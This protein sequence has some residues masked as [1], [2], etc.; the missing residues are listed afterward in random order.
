MH[1]LLL[2][3]TS[4]TS[5]FII[6]YSYVEVLMKLFI[7]VK[8]KSLNGEIVL[9]TGAAHGL[10]RGTAYAFAKHGCKLVLWDINKVHTE[11]SSL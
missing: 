9:I 4:V 5:L 8:K 7:P 3:V 6:L 11:C 10:G 2:I 1:S